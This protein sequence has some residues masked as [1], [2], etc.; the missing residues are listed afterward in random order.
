MSKSVFAV[1]ILFLFST[2]CTNH[3]IRPST[4]PIAVEVSEFI[5]GKTA[6][7][8]GPALQPY[9]VYKMSGGKLYGA[10]ILHRI[11][12]DSLEL[13]PMKELSSDKYQIAS[14]LRLL[15]PNNVFSETKTL[16]GLMNIDTGYDFVKVSIEA[17]ATKY[18]EIGD[19][20]YPEYIASFKQAFDQDLVKLRQ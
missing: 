17:G 20:G 2:G 3:D 12:P 11:N 1:V 14:S 6:G 8:V 13:Y 4:D 7:P 16:I 18:F 15:L 19:A 10:Y 5:F 9:N